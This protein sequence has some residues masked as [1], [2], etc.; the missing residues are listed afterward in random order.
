MLTDVIAHALGLRRLT[1]RPNERALVLARGKLDRI[2]VPGQYWMRNENV[3][4]GVELHDITR[5]EFTSVFDRALFRERPDVAAQHLTE[6]RTGPD[7]VAIVQR[8]NR[9]HAVVK[10]QDRVVYWTDA[11]PWTVER[12][13]VGTDLVVPEAVARRVLGAGKGA[14]VLMAVEVGEAHVGLL[15]ADG[16]FIGSLGPGI[17]VLWTVV[18]KPAVK[19]VD[20]RRQALEVAGQEVLTRDRVTLRVNLVAEY[21]IVDAVKAALSVKDPVEALYRALQLAF[22]KSL[23]SKTLDAI[24]ADKVEADAEA[25]AQVRTEMA[26]IGVLVGEIAVKDV[27]LPG[28]MRDILN[29]VVA[30]EKEAEAN[31]IRR[32]EETNATRSLL[33]TA[34][35]MAEN[36][37]MLRLKEL[38]ALAEIA[39]KVERLTVHNGTVGLLN[40]LVSLRP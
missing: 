8:E 25:A 14:G 12:I 1:V 2:L 27:I 16:V 35:I 38:E 4:S 6:V 10:P 7:E 18:R 23:G 3:R 9:V 31:V 20:L 37:T 22:R 11:G 5:P 13:A 15:T 39:G 40:D 17:H 28:E 29:R 21:Q 32:R 34:R 30:A 26:A 19:L 36:P 33:N 24:L